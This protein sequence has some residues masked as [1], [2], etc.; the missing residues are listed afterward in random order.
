MLDRLTCCPLQDIKATKM[1]DIN[2][3]HQIRSVH[4]QARDISL[5][6]KFSVSQTLSNDTKAEGAKMDCT[7]S[8]M[9][10]FPQPP[11]EPVNVHRSTNRKHHPM[12]P[13]Y[14]IETPILTPMPDR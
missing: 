2:K 4:K 14:I 5:D 1:P 7:A 9:L 10:F 13:E 6:L 8:V 11:P 3:A 12:V